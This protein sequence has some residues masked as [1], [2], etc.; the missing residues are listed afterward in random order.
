A[1]KDR[2]EAALRGYRNPSRSASGEIAESKTFLHQFTR[3]RSW[4]AELQL[5]D[6]SGSETRL[7]DEGERILRH[8]EKTTGTVPVR[9]PPSAAL[10]HDAFQLQDDAIARAWGAIVDDAFWESSLYR[11]DRY[12][13][14]VPTDAEFLQVFDWAFE[15]VRIKQVSEA[16]LS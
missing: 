10:L 14:Y 6:R 5:V 9:I 12:G 15:Q 3:S 2:Q 4:L 11:L 13:V 8:F 7:T 1:K 16:S